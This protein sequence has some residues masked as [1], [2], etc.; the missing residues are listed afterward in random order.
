MKKYYT[1][2]GIVLSLLIIWPVNGATKLF[3]YQGGTGTTTAPSYGQL[4]VGTSGRVYQLQATSTLGLLTGL[5]NNSLAKGNFIVGND[6]G[7]SQATST[8][9][10]NSTGNVGIGTTAPDSP[11]TVS[12]S[13]AIAY[14]PA[15]TLT[16]GQWLRVS[17]P[18]STA[19]VA[20]NILFEAN[21]GGGGNGIATISGVHTSTGSM[22]LTFGTRD[23]SGNVIERMRLS[24]NGNVG[25]GT[26][27]PTQ[28]LTLNTGQILV[29]VD[30]SAGDTSLYLR[31]GAVGDKARIILN[32][33]GTADYII[34]VGD[35]AGKLSL[36][37]TQAGSDG[38][39]I[40][41]SGNV[42]IASTTPW[43]LLSVNPNGITGPAFAIGSST[44]TD[45]I[46]TNGGNFGIGTT[47]PLYKFSINSGTNGFG[48]DSSGIVKQGTWQGNTIDV[49]YGG[50]GATTITGLVLGNGTSAMSAYTGTSCT[51][52]FPRSL[53]ASGAAT[54]A[55]VANTDLSN[56][57]IGLTSLGSIIV[58][59]SPI[60]LG[61]TSALNLNMANANTWTALQ[62]FSNA[63]TTNIGS[64]GSA[65]FA[66]SGGNV[67]IGTASPTEKL[68]IGGTNAL[69]GEK[70][71]DASGS[72]YDVRTNSD[73]TWVSYFGK[74][75][76]SG[77]N[78]F[79]TSLPEALAV[80]T[81]SNHP[82]VFAA[83]NLTRMAILGSGN[84][85]I[86]TTTPASL[87]HVSAGISAT[88]TIEF[89]AQDIT[90]K[91]CFNIRDVLGAATSFYF[92]G[93]TMIIEANRC[94]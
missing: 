42:G 94:K 15:N 64:T 71:T 3:P 21:G 54:C 20:S 40:D 23:D 78:L 67:G 48:I 52:Q 77:N 61:G 59:T 76:T 56:S 63:S 13:N 32:H 51:N 70:G 44:K 30:G 45:L 1:I 22:A 16:N 62:T 7:L 53:N 68:S 75:N 26:T 93:T 8:I 43:G 41:G 55:S 6:D 4:L 72:F 69:L 65:Y 38:I 28:K 89:G 90:S 46:V 24:S 92:Q 31:G 10:I 50:T 73:S 74:D 58:G 82:L 86:G 29:G 60:S 87:L 85:G 34:A 18:D 79:A 47:S 14:T 49:P 27:A 19:G 36:T 35:I 57:T 88:T 83:N 9:F 91:T 84:V 5:T 39:I 81:A 37:K 33:Y 25:I 12:V 80:G 17:N 11:L 2:L 66:T